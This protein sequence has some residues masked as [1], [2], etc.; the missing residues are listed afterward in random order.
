MQVLRRGIF[1]GSETTEVTIDS[2]GDKFELIHLFEMP[3][4][5]VQLVCDPPEYF[6]FV[7]DR[8]SFIFDVKQHDIVQ[9]Q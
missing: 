7:L 3:Q 2:F 1:D 8:F 9:Y 5:I 6:R 4:L